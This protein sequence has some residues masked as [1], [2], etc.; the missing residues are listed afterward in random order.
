[1]RS[2]ESIVAQA[3]FQNIDTEFKLN[4]FFKHHNGTIAPEFYVVWPVYSFWNK[5]HWFVNM[6]QA[7]G[8]VIVWY[9]TY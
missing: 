9:K 6:C 4:F 8:V 2:A 5:N 1:M 7:D 3:Q